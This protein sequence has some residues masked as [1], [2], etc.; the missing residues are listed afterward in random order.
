M[1]ARV[2]IGPNP[3]VQVADW[4]APH[5]RRDRVTHEVSTTMTRA[6]S[7]NLRIKM[8]AKMKNTSVLLCCLFLIYTNFACVAYLYPDLWCIW[9][10]LTNYVCQ[11]FSE[12]TQNSLVVNAQVL[13]QR[14]SIQKARLPVCKGAH[15]VSEQ[16]CLAC[17]DDRQD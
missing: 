4:S 5:S 11:P 2:R 7:P 10:I 12:Q 14:I 1:Q 15:N 6:P 9:M 8:S 17:K 3:Q 16:S 13:L